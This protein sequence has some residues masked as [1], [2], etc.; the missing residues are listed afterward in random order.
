MVEGRKRSG[1]KDKIEAIER[2]QKQEFEYS[3]GLD[4]LYTVY[5]TDVKVQDLGMKA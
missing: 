4:S 3:R 1:M 5:N 2:R